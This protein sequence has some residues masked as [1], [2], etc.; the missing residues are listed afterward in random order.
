MWVRIRDDMIWE[1]RTVELLGI[2]I[3]N[4]LKFDGHLT[5][6]CIK[7]NRK[8][9]VLTRMR[10]YLDFNKMR[11]LFK[12]FFESQFKYCPLTWMFYSRKT[13]N[14]I[15]KLHERALRLVYS[16][17]ESTFEDLLT[18]DGLAWRGLKSIKVKKK[19]FLLKII[20]SCSYT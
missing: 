3:D 17:Y 13:N 2:T 19:K 1:N 8:L 9:T 14:R 11:L 7:A 20:H 16:D 10:R 15:N 18:K 6:I 4:E 5:N 12:S